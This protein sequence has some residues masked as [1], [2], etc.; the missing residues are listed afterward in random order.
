MEQQ[1]DDKLWQIAQRRANFRRSLFTY[2]ISNAFFWCIWW[3]TKG[4]KGDWEGVPWPIWV[5]LGWGFILG[6]Q[7]Y[8]A[9]HG[10]KSD[11]AEKEY[12]KLKREGR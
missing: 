5:M 8:E 2:L 11:L 12:E 9:Y 4:T 10:T 7:Y 6:K 1:K 3:F